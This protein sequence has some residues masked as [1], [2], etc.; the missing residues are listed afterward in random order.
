MLY[1]TSMVANTIPLAHM[2]IEESLNQS[3]ILMLQIGIVYLLNNVL[4]H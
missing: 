1:S 2:F 3:L 4:K